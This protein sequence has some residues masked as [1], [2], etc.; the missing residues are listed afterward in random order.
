[1]YKIIF[2]SLLEGERDTQKISSLLLS[3]SELKLKEPTSRPIKVNRVTRKKFPKSVQ[4]AAAVRE[5][6][7]THGKCTICGARLPF[8][9]RSQDHK[10]DVAKGGTGSLNNLEYT[11]PYC[12]SVKTKLEAEGWRL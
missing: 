9:S 6:L 4:A 2:N 1:M 3:K 10:I 5:A 11:H 7:K 12:N 8:Y